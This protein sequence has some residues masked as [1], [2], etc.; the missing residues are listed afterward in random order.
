M[1]VAGVA[2][3]AGPAAAGS[4][5][6]QI[7]FYDNVGTVY[8]IMLIGQD[9]NGDPATGCFQTPH[10]R[11]DI[12]GWW[13]KGFLTVRA[14][15]DSGCSERLAEGEVNVPKEQSSDYTAAWYTNGQIRW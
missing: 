11:T 8:S 12:N 6:Q 13:W 2:L 10:S 14:Y 15:S 4:N 5:G 9:Q 7:R 3:A 1:A